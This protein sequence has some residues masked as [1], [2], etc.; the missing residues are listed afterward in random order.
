MDDFDRF[1]AQYPR[2][3][4][5]KDARKAWEQIAPS[6]ELVERMIAALVWQRVQ[7]QWVKDGGAYIPLP[8]S[9]LRAEQ[10]DDEPVTVSPVRPALRPQPLQQFDEVERLKR[11]GV[12]HER[13]VRKV[14]G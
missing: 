12:D 6:S 10:W 4:K 14:Y 11:A 7:P 3:Q 13:A 8:A 1:W 5:K 9:W 2:R